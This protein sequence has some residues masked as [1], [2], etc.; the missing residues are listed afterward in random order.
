MLTEVVEVLG[1]NLF[2]LLGDLVKV[3]SGLG[4]VLPTSLHRLRSRLLVSLV[5]TAF[6]HKHRFHHAV[7][8][9]TQVTEKLFVDIRQEQ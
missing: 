2:T 3:G 1:G 8:E 6:G 7:E 4:A 9:L 5:R